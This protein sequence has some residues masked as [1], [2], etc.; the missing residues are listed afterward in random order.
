MIR[1]GRKLPAD[2][3]TRVASLPERIQEEESV[4]ALYLHGSAVAGIMTP[5]SDLDFGVLLKHGLGKIG[6]FQKHLHLACLFEETLETE[7]FD[8]IMMN[9]APPRIAFNIL[10]TGKLLF[11]R[12][13]D[14]F[15][16]F[17]EKV[18]KLYL[19]FKPMREEYNAIFIE[20][21]QKAHS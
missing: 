20:K 6:R 12:D 4:C 7:E 16:D 3:M 13:R 1:T 17:W 10:K 2:I 11:V 15:V 18:T 5:L 8:L 21:L 9:E 19:D 14:E